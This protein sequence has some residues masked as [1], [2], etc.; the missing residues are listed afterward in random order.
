V[1]KNNLEPN[2]F[3]DRM[4]NC[5]TTKCENDHCVWQGDLL[6]LVQVHQT[7]CGFIIH[8]CVNIGCSETYFKKDVLLHKEDCLFKLIECTYCQTDIPKKHMEAHVEECLNEQV[9][10]MYYD[11]GCKNEL[12]RR[13][14]CSHEETHQAKHNRLIYQDSLVSKNEVTFLKQKIVVI[15]K[16]IQ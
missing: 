11:I 1:K 5:L 12:C 16:K 3:V 15:K 14:I 6:Y 9:E 10:C 4:V 13:D 7:N 8:A 2:E